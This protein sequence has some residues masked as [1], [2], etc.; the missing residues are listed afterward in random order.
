MWMVLARLYGAERVGYCT[1]WPRKKAA[2]CDGPSLGRI[3]MPSRTALVSY[4]DSSCGRVAKYTQPPPNHGV[5]RS[6]QPDIPA[7]HCFPFSPISTAH[8]RRRATA[9][10]DRSPHWQ[11]SGAIIEVYG[12][13]YVY[14]ATGSQQQ[15]KPSW[16]IVGANGIRS[17]EMIRMRPSRSLS[18][19]IVK[20]FV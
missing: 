3:V 10:R 11:T 7:N 4:Y 16:L 13:F 20:S 14:G 5:R 17:R 6:A 9:R 12:R 8:G 15:R 1:S 2:I 18:S 19:R